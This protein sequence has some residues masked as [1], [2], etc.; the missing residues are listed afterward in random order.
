MRK[1]IKTEMI[2]NNEECIGIFLKA[3]YVGE[4]EH[5]IDDLKKLFNI[6]NTS[7][8]EFMKMNKK[9]FKSY[10]LGLLTN[11]NKKSELNVTQNQHGNYIINTSQFYTNLLLEHK[12][13]NS[14][15]ISFWDNEDFAI[16]TD[17]ADFYYNFVEA[18]ERN[19]LCFILA[20][21]ICNIKDERGGLCILFKDK[22]PQEFIDDYIQ[23]QNDTIDFLKVN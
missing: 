7:I 19:N 16:V 4:H 9:T 21:E 10:P 1:S 23:I 13:K 11:K 6:F 5:G 8:E 17:D 12:I 2:I 3:D 18:E 14:K 15:T 20:D 22:V